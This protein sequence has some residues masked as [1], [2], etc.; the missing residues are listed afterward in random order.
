MIKAQVQWSG[1]STNRNW[2]VEI[3]KGNWQRFDMASKAEADKLAEFI[4]THQITPT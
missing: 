4:N 2:F 1:N 3:V